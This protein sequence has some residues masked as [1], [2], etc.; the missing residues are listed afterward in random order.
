VVLSVAPLLAE[1]IERIHLSQ[2]VS[3]T[4]GHNAPSQKRLF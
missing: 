3:A 1:A 4:I 2:S